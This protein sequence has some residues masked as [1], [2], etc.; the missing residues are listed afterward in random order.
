MFDGQFCNRELCTRLGSHLL[1][2]TPVDSRYSARHNFWLSLVL[3]D[4]FG[5]RPRASVQ[6]QTGVALVLGFAWSS[7]PRFDRYR[8][9]SIHFLVASHFQQIWSMA[10]EKFVVFPKQDSLLSLDLS[11]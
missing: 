8:S 4:N 9:P 6:T 11:Y 2:P 1:S 3:H 10:V 5:L 7:L